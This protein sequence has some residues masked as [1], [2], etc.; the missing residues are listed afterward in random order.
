MGQRGSHPGVDQDWVRKIS[1]LAR[2]KLTEEEISEL[3]PQLGQILDHVDQLR[4]V[5][6][7]GVEPYVHPLIE[8][9]PD[10][11]LVSLRDDVSRPPE[12]QKAQSASVLHGAPELVEN[13]FQVPQAV[14]QGGG[15]SK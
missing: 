6:T 13:S 2:L 7:E 10:S 5:P 8:I 11:A 12:D 15:R 4:A 14:A 1:K 9:L 3:L